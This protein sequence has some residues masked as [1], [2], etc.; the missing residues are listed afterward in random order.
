MIIKMFLNFYIIY[1]LNRWISI[2]YKTQLYIFCVCIENVGM[3]TIKIFESDYLWVMLIETGKGLL[4]TL[5]HAIYYIYNSIIIIDNDK[6][7]IWCI[8]WY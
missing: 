8:H 2:I 1:R 4:C 5:S 7:I 6:K 3:D